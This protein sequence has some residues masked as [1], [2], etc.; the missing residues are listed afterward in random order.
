MDAT[1]EEGE[2]VMEIAL[3]NGCRLFVDRETLGDKRKVTSVFVGE[4][5]LRENILSNATLYYI[6]GAFVGS[7][8]TKEIDA[9]VAR[10]TL[11]IHSLPQFRHLINQ[12]H[13]GKVHMQVP[14]DQ[15]A[16]VL[17]ACRIS[18][19]EMHLMPSMFECLGQTKLWE[20]RPDVPK[21]K[22]W[23]E[24]TI[25]KV[26][27]QDDPACFHYVA[28]MAT[29]TY[30]TFMDAIDALGMNVV[31]PHLKTVNEGSRF[32]HNIEGY[33]EASREYGVR[34]WRMMR[35]IN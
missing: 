24:S 14:A 32:Y 12:K 33:S 35:L 4:M 8:A 23:D 6:N 15:G 1:V 3:E 22:H 7:Q 13:D 2:Y 11:I 10:N 17:Q 16:A 21:R 28:I 31:I 20:I 30:P 26:M 27:N 9:I 5:G 29:L 19:G 34:A 25:V 18:F